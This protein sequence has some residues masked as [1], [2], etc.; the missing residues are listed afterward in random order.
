MSGQYKN[1]FNYPNIDILM[2]TIFIIQ[3]SI[4]WFGQYLYLQHHVLLPEP[5]QALV[6]YGG[7]QLLHVRMGH[8]LSNKY[9]SNIS[10]DGPQ[11]IKQIS[12][13]YQLGWATNCQHKYEQRSEHLKGRS[14]L[15]VC[16][17]LD[18]IASKPIIQALYIAAAPILSKISVQTIK[19]I[20]AK[21]QPNISQISVQYQPKVSANISQRL[22]K[23]QLIPKLTLFCLYLIAIFSLFRCIRSPWVYTGPWIYKYILAPLVNWFLLDFRSFQSIFCQQ[24]IL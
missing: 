1:Q 19:Q 5:W 15:S 2:S 9:Q 16:L 10:Q 4:F 3:I 14:G 24:K 12:V 11:T 20:S 22:V 8:K 21:Y 13:Q 18:Q 6:P 7:K 23:H 17:F